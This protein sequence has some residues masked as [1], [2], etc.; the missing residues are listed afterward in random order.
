MQWLKITNC[1]PLTWTS[2]KSSETSF[3]NVGDG[4]KCTR[5]MSAFGQRVVVAILFLTAFMGT[6]KYM[7]SS[8]L[9][10]FIAFFSTSDS[11]SLSIAFNRN[12]E[13]LLTPPPKTYPNRL[14]SLVSELPQST[15]W[16]AEPGPSSSYFI[17][18]FSS[19]DWWLSERPFL[20]AIG[21]FPRGSP[22]IFLVTPEFEALRASLIELPKD[23]DGLVTWVKWRED[24]SPYEALKTSLDDEVDAFV[25]DGLTRQFVAEGL[26]NVLREEK[27]DEVLGKIGL[28]RERKSRWEVE[29][30]RCANQKTLHA[31][32]KTKKRM[33]LGISE[34]RTS[35]IL[36]EE[37]TKIGLVGGEGLVLFGSEFLFDEGVLQSG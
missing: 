36:E 10:E 35:R 9:T 32:R 37:M 5:P 34:S 27:N 20:V 14:D 2:I 22:R 30:L 19:Q 15:V 28:I 18:R 6:L 7:P 13:A 3:G 4:H 1:I 23:L 17:G 31:I 33:H 12:C 16:V 24:Q 21:R 29:L 26:R 25:L 11:S 8:S